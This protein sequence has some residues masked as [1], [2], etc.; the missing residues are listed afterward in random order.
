[1]RSERA[2]VFSK[3]YGSL[4]LFLNENEKETWNENK[5]EC[6]ELHFSRCCG[7]PLNV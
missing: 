5:V 4:S 3:L 2:W 7:K 1:M 6:Q